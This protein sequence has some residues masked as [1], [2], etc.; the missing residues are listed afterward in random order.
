MKIKMSIE[1]TLIKLLIKLK[2]LK[3]YKIEENI[4]R[5]NKKIVKICIYTQNQIINL[6]LS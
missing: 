2:C 5:K 6:S 4:C 1:K 3:I